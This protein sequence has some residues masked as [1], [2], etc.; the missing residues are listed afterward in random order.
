M[1][2]NIDSNISSSKRVEYYDVCK[3]IAAFCVILQH[4]IN[5]KPYLFARKYSF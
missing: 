1:I 3:G 4:F 5:H 2:N